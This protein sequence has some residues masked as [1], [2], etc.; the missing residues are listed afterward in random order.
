MAGHRYRI[1]PTG[2]VGAEN[3]G[4]GM[5]GDGYPLGVAAAARQKTRGEGRIGIFD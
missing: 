1:G 3:E 5:V 4:A 2:R